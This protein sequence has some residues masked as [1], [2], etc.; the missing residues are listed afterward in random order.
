MTGKMFLS[1]NQLRKGMDAARLC[2]QEQCMTICAGG[3]KR[4]ETIH[5]E[6]EIPGFEV[7]LGSF[8]QPTVKG[9]TRVHGQLGNIDR[10]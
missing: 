8:E 3:F 4:K 6:L 10:L 7:R 5:L 9:Q 1:G 2:W